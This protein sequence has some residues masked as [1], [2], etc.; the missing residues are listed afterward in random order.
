MVRRKQIATLAR[1]SRSSTAARS[2]SGVTSHHVT[3]DETTTVAAKKLQTL[4]N[5]SL[6]SSLMLMGKT[7]NIA[8]HLVVLIFVTNAYDPMRTIVTIMNIL[9]LIRMLITVSFSSS[10]RSPYIQRNKE[11]DVSLLRIMRKA[12]TLQEKMPKQFE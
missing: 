12:A 7:A 9:V 2:Y 11:N 8:Q 5:I 3:R 4:H 10:L 6:S 1:F